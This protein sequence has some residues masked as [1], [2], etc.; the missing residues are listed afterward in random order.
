MCSTLPALITGTDRDEAAGRRLG[1]SATDA[2]LFETSSRNLGEPV[3][4][5][6]LRCFSDQ[7]VAEIV[8]CG[9]SIIGFNTSILRACNKT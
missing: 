3:N 8:Q 4:N 9:E 6:P 1:Y 2:S 7:P 5:R